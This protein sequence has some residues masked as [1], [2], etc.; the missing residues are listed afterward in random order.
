MSAT[1]T[2]A[3][4]VAEARRR[5]R[6]TR[7]LSSEQA[8]ELQKVVE[9]F[10]GARPRNKVCVC[11]GSAIWSEHETAGG[12][13]IWCCAGCHRPASLT[14]DEWHAQRGAA[15]AVR[16]VQDAAAAAAAPAPRDAMQAALTARADA[17]ARIAKLEPG[18][19]AA[20]AALAAAQVRHDAATAAMAEAEQGAITRLAASVM[21]TRPEA[22]AITQGAARGGLRSAEDALA[23][24]RG[25]KALLDGQIA[26]AR[27]SVSFAETAVRTAALSVLANEN[28]E[29]LIERAIE[30]RADY[31]EAVSGLGWLIRNGATPNGDARAHQLVIGADVAPARWPEAQHTDGGMTARLAA[32]ME[33]GSSM[34][35]TC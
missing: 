12:D 8:D 23:A 27:R 2:A 7:S 34:S 21:G 9:R 31:L 4:S 14:Q 16:R 13:A 35:T 22:A 19:A 24:A 5:L 10:L 1:I 32:L 25:A 18:L 33:G 28:L 17:V 11:C 26:E 6:D 29:P 15:E 3:M 30:A 20:R